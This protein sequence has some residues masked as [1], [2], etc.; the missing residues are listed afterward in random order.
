MTAIVQSDHPSYRHVDYMYE[1]EPDQD[2]EFYYFYDWFDKFRSDLYSGR[3]S[4]HEEM[5]KLGHSKK[6]GTS[7][8]P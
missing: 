1:F 5:K 2:G 3:I 7:V 4:L 8:R 6:N